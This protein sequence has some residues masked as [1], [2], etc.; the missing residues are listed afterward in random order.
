MVK[1]FWRISIP[2]APDTTRRMTSWLSE[3]LWAK[4]ALQ[5]LSARDASRLRDALV[6]SNADV[7]AV[8]QE[9]PG[10]APLEFAGEG[11][12]DARSEK[13]AT[14]LFASAISGDTLLHLALR[15]HDPTCAR[16]LVDCGARLDASN[17]AKETPLSLLWDVQMASIVAPHKVAYGDLLGHLA[18]ALQ[19]Y[20][21]ANHARARD[22]LIALYTRVAPDRLPKVDAQL[23]EFFG[24]EM[25]LLRRVRAKYTAD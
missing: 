10:G 25:E 20:Q 3:P 18:P 9:F 7:N 6:N 14:P 21:A 17:S 22:E 2:E 12:Y 15:Q 5:A 13:W 24:R 16:V 8:V 1:L 19:R 23:R 11:F 4:E